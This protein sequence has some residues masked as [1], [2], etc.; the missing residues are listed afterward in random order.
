MKIIRTTTMRPT[1][2]NRES[3]NDLTPFWAPS[4]VGA[5]CAGA[6]AGAGN[7]EEI[8]DLFATFGNELDEFRLDIGV[9]WLIF[10]DRVRS[11]SALSST[12]EYFFPFLSVC[13]PQVCFSMTSVLRVETVV[14]LD[15]CSSIIWFR[16][17]ENNYGYCLTIKMSVI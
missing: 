2:H 9:V 13:L 4:C 5:D 10:F 15:I 11:D 14:D 1:W 16:S 3:R 6:G 7:A 17:N 12:Y 8:L